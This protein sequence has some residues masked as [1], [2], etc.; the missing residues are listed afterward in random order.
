MALGPLPN[1]VRS[2]EH[3]KDFLSLSSHSFKSERSSLRLSSAGDIFCFT[4]CQ[5][6]LP[7][8]C[9]AGGGHLRGNR[10]LPPTILLRAPPP[11]LLTLPSSPLP[12]PILSYLPSCAPLSRHAFPTSP[13]KP[14]SEPRP[15]SRCV[16]E[17]PPTGRH[18]RMAVKSSSFRLY[19][20][21]LQGPGCGDCAVTTTCRGASWEGRRS[22]PGVKLKEGE[23]VLSPL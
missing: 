5:P 17:E 20:R 19:V 6:H 16:A 3:C 1:L 13:R 23:A 12:S 4:H 7:C 18:C 14:L 22:G 21:R 15:C 10:R 9:F 8:G 11:S 2:L